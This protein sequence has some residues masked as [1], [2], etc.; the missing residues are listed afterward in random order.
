MDINLSSKKGAT[1]SGGYQSGAQNRKL[2]FTFTEVI[3]LLIMIGLFYWYMVSPKQAVLA[4]KKAQI[5]KLTD[6][7]SKIDGEINGLKDSLKVLSG[8]KTEIAEM[9]EALPMDS[10]TTKLQMLVN[11]L[12]AK[13]GVSLESAGFDEDPKKVYAADKE[14]IKE[15]FSQARS[16]KVIHGSVSVLGKFDQIQLFLNK[17]ENSA[18]ILKIT[19]MELQ[20]QKDS[21][22]SLVLDLE[23]YSYE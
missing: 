21:V 7:K 22:M 14:A 10:R 4:E 9:D 6:D 11:D 13:A 5:A 2:S 18:R 3:L 20:A 16:L 19:S 23:A 15:P 12:A 8:N 17:I 1:F